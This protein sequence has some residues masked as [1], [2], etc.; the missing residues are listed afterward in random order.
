[1]LNSKQ[2]GPEITNEGYIVLAWHMTRV[3]VLE[4]ALAA[5]ARGKSLRAHL[6]DVAGYR[7]NRW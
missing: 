7:T 4:H 5:Q 6:E 1:M 2:L 3:V